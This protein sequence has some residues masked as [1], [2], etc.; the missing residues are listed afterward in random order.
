MIVPH[1]P[2]LEQKLAEQLSTISRSALSL[3]L[4]FLAES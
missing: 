1:L 2:A 4:S 3:R